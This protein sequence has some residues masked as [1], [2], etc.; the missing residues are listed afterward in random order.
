MVNSNKILTVSY[1]TFSCTL[2]GF[3][4]SFDTMK[5]IAEYFRDL[6]QDDRYFGAEPPTPD[7]DML[8]RIA[9]REI[10]RRVETRFEKGN[11]VLR[12]AE[13][14]DQFGTRPAAAAK[15]VESTPP[16]PEAEAKA[17]APAHDDAVQALPPAETAPL[18]PT[19]PTVEPRPAPATA[20]NAM[21]VMS[22]S[23]AE[24]L[25]R[26]RAVVAA[27]TQAP[28][29][30]IEDE[31]ALP[32]QDSDD[33]GAP[34]FIAAPDQDT[35]PSDAR[36]DDDATAPVAEQT[37]TQTAEA[38][39]EDEAEK[40][41]PKTSAPE[42]DLQPPASADTSDDSQAE[43]EALRAK[44]AA[45][46]AKAIAAQTDKTAEVADVDAHGAV[47]PTPLTAVEYTAPATD[48]AVPD[49]DASN[50]GATGSAPVPHQPL[51]ARV[52]IAPRAEVEAALT[53]D[54]M[55]EVSED[56]HDDD[57]QSDAGV[58][59]DPSDDLISFDVPS[60]KD[61]R[62][63][64]SDAMT[65]AH[66]TKLDRDLAD[67]NADLGTDPAWDSENAEFIEG[68][69][70]QEAHPTSALNIDEG[71]MASANVRKTVKL[72]NPARALLTD[73]PI[74]QD[75]QAVD[76]LADKTDS[77]ME[78]PEGN[79]RRSA[80]AHL[81]AAVAATRADRVLGFG[82]KSTSEEEP[83]REDLADAV[84]PR[85]PKATEIRSARPAAMRPSPLKL[86]AE[87][88]VDVDPSAERAPVHP[89]RVQSAGIPAKSAVP[90]ASNDTD[91]AEFAANQ[92]AHTLPELLEAAAA[93]M[94]FVEGHDQ[95]SRPQLMTKLAQTKGKTSSREE[96]LISFGR[97]LREGKIEKKGG[98]R[99]AASDSIGFRP[100]AS[101]AR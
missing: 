89:R 18:A 68:T 41:T 3:D 73:T 11:L 61:A 88:R 65:P 9:E 25:K 86:V 21:P 19:S 4:N 27:K 83:Y 46:E 80:I 70:T 48:T 14:P 54:Q 20:M 49:T 99:F 100:D 5:A 78:E 81:R 62:H 69:N 26:I 94:S 13:D 79:R 87:Q 71:D 57:P 29:D 44:I 58:D 66:A 12:A 16:Q 101:A 23:V 7:A 96:Q 97:L 45:L 40:V 22:D 74:E 59:I 72:N 60:A 92:G 95:F 77:A 38:G 51:R 28:Q 91:F 24:K 85:R 42:T 76:R 67:V 34:D 2:E 63:T 35:N 30:Y 32:P 36:F 8:A 84:R 55:E 17:E 56:D 33:A 98:G 10:A 52:S 82:K 43:L 1:G 93:Y 15:T 50:T 31:H 64:K 75:E 47:D 90:S 39:A 6:A 53:A 37:D